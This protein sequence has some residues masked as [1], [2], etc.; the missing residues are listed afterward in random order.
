[1]PLAAVWCVQRADDDSSP[2]VA[3]DALRC[4]RLLLGDAD[5]AA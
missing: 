3:L 5:R 2:P 1:M 4:A